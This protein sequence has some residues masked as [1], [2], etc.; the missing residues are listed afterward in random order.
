M[1][2]DLTRRVNCRNEL[3]GAGDGEAGRI[4]GVREGGADSVGEALGVDTDLDEDVE[5]GEEGGGDGDEAGMAVVDEHVGGERL[6]GAVGEAA[7]AVGGIGEDE[8]VVGGVRLEEGREEVGKREGEEEQTLRKLQR[9]AAGAGGA[10]AVRRLGE[11]EVVRRREEAGGGGGEGWVGEDGG[12]DGRVDEAL[13]GRLP[14][15]S[16]RGARG[17][18]QRVR[19]GGLAGVHGGGGGGGWERA[20]AARGFASPEGEKRGYQRFTKLIGPDTW[21][22]SPGRKKAHAV[23]DSRPLR[24]GA[25]SNGPSLSIQGK[26]R[27]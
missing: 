13:R 23:R 12:R 25:Q 3:H 11:L 1:T 20:A 21:A 2:E 16:M 10:D 22:E 4:G 27:G 14:L 17:K 19:G 8:D 24:A 7:R 18:Y 6:G 15:W 5:H 26:L 9:G